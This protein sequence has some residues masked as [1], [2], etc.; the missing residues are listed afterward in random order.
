M[1][2]CKC[3]C[4]KCLTSKYDAKYFMLHNLGLPFIDLNWINTKNMGKTVCSLLALVCSLSPCDRSEKGSLLKSGT[5]KFQPPLFYV[6]TCIT[7]FRYLSITCNALVVSIDLTTAHKSWFSYSRT[8][9][10]SLLLSICNVIVNQKIVQSR[11]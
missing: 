1:P 3:F 11:I 10:D 5:K 9:W 4:C 6:L 7:S 8:Y 2:P